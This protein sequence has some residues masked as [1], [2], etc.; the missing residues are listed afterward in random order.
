[1]TALTWAGSP[2][3]VDV[4]VIPRPVSAMAPSDGDPTSATTQLKTPRIFYSDDNL[5]ESVLN[6]QRMLDE[7]T[8]STVEVS[9]IDSMAKPKLGPNLTP[10]FVRMSTDDALKSKGE[11]AYE[12]DIQPNKVTIEV[13]GPKGVFM[14]GRLWLN[15]CRP[16]SST[17]LP[18]PRSPYAGLCP[19]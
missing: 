16:H 1:M 9:K 2:A 18:K 13:N 19:S 5:R 12:L 15:C 14:R 4:P 3:S 7:G 11:E 10:V 6:L 17:R 8:G